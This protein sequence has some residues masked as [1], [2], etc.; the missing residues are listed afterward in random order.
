MLPTLVTAEI[1]RARRKTGHLEAYDYLLRSWAFGRIY[2][3]EAAWEALGHARRAVALDPDFALA[4]AGIAANLNMLRSFGWSTDRA[5]ENAEAE[6]AIRRALELDSSDPRV[7]ALCA[8]TLFICLYRLQEAAALLDQAVRLDPN[9]SQA[10]I[11]RASARIALDEPEKAIGDVERTLRL[12]PLDSLKFYGLTLLGR[13]H[14]MCG[15]YDKALPLIAESLRLRPNFQGA[16]V[17]ATVA[18]ALVGDLASARQSLIAYQQVAPGMTIATYRQRLPHLSAS[19]AEIYIR[20]LRL[21][22]MPE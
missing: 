9:N 4:H 17:D 16:L 12:S 7:L 22:G 21:A 19:G 5:A 18:H 8:Q 15:R 1:E 6:R 10:L 11:N 13:A 3:A 14:T 2:S 20:G